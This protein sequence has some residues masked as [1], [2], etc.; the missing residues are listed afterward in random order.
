MQLGTIPPRPWVLGLF[1][2]VLATSTQAAASTE[3]FEDLLIL[4]FYLLQEDYLFQS[5]KFHHKM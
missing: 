1:V 4:H 5:K 3:R 2:L